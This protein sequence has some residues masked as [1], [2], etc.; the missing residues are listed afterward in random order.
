MIIEKIMAFVIKHQLH[1]NNGNWYEH[2]NKTEGIV[3]FCVINS[4]FFCIKMVQWCLVDMFI[5]AGYKI[6]IS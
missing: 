3:I 6:I 2:K 1:P 4:L 5:M